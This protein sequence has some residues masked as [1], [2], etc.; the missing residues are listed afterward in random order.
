MV[1]A[2]YDER[3]NFVG[4]EPRLCGEHRTVGPHRAWC[5]DCR[6]WCYPDPEIA[7]I[8]CNPKVIEALS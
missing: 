6:E 5:F 2:L 7:C 4:F 1:T 3:G 8:R